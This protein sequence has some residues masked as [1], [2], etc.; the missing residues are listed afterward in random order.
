MLVTLCRCTVHFAS[1]RGK[2][3]KKGKERKNDGSV[4]KDVSVAESL[5]CYH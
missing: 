1:V 5:Q 2:D 4:R 3:I